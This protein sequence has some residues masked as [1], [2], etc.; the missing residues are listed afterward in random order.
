VTVSSGDE[1]AP[2]EELL[3][4]LRRVTL[5]LSEADRRSTVDPLL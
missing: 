3:E 5:E 4:H 2:P 1:H